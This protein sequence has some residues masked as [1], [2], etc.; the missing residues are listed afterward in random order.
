MVGVGVLGLLLVLV[1]VMGVA[2][3]AP[4]PIKDN[5]DRATKTMAASRGTR[6]RKMS[7]L[8]VLGGFDRPVAASSLSRP[9]SKAFA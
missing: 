2:P 4:H 9:S 7:G 6:L 8:R 5:K 3:V 1:V